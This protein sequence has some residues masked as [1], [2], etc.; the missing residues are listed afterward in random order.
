MALLC[1]NGDWIPDCNDADV[2]KYVPYAWNGSIFFDEVKSVFYHIAFKSYKVYS[3]F[4]ENHEDLL[5][6]YFEMD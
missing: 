4:F 5:K 1:Y 6:Q 3:A 2:N